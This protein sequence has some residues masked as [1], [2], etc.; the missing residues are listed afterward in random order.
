M[1]TR[2]WLS[3][4]A[5]GATLAAA[6]AYAQFP[7]MDMV[8]DRV[9]QRYQA[10]TCEQLWERRG[11]QATPEELNLAAML[12]NDPQMRQAFFNRIAI[13]V[14]GKMFDCGLIP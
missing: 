1:K 12:R 3:G 10:A 6:A 11:K 14:M 8:A 13:P 2:W 4:V 9:I 5:A 7:I